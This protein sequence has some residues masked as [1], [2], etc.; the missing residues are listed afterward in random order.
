MT[1]PEPDAI[2]E[3]IEFS[4][5]TWFVKYSEA[6]VGPQNNI[7]SNRGSDIWVDEIGRLHM[8]L[9][10]REDTWYCTEVY[11]E[12]SFGYGTYVFY[13][14]SRIDHLDK[15]VVFG[16][17]TYDEKKKNNHTEIDI[18]FAKWGKEHGDSA[19]FVVQPGHIEGNIHSFSPVQWSEFSTHLFYWTPYAISF[20]SIGGHYAHAPTKEYLIASWKYQGEYIPP[21]G[22]E[23]VR[24]NLYMLEDTPPSNGKSVEVIINKFEFIPFQQ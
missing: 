5:Y 7:F 15:N 6:R 2:Y 20:Q 10:Y 16:L 12:Q 4:G 19:Q 17:F 1:P 21:E 3:K 13:L 18:E 8:T 14:D 22:K 9:Q 24:I 23:K 11:T